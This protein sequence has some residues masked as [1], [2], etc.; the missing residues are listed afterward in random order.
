[1]TGHLAGTFL[2][3]VAAE[4]ADPE[5]FRRGRVY[6][7]QHAVRDVAVQ[8]GVVSAAVQ[9]SRREP[10]QVQL[11]VAPL[12]AGQQATLQ[13]ASVDRVTLLVPKPRELRFSCSC[14]DFGDPCKHA[15]AVLLELASLVAEDPDLLV[16]WRG[17]G[18]FEVP[19]DDHGL[20]PGMTP[21]LAAYFG[22]DAEPV[23]LR[24]VTPLPP[25]APDDEAARLLADALGAL[26][27][28]LS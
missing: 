27:S 19:E 7:R 24:P 11:R 9:G 26:R 25:P 23:L 15:V 3:T 12:R 13:G 20:E 6:A 18:G 14:P 21:E 5:R 22:L 8:P 17:A 10:Y 28:V 2:M 16:A 1:M 4:V